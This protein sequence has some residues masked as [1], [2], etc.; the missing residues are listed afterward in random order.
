[1]S[2]KKK[3]LLSY[4]LYEFT[5]QSQEDAGPF[6]PVTVSRKGFGMGSI[7]KKAAMVASVAA[8]H[9]Y[10]ATSASTSHGD[11]LMMVPMK[12]CLMS[13]SLPWEYIAHDLLFKVRHILFIFMITQLLCYVHFNS[14]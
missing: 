5:D 13:V 9:A 11:E 14:N 8:K 12:C 6:S 7:F 2:K 10:A 4:I 3:T 1:M